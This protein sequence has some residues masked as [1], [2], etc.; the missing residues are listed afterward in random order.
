MKS[1]TDKLDVIKRLTD[2]EVEYWTARDLLAILGYVEWRNFEQAIK[3]ARMA[4]D[5]AGEKSENHFVETTNMVSVGSG[6]MRSVPDYYLSRA[7]CYIISMNGDTRKKEIAEA[8]KYFAIQT[9]RMERV[10]LALANYRRV[11]LRNRV[12]VHNQQLSGAA[13]DV[14][15]RR[16]GVFHG[17]GIKGMYNMTLNALRQ[18]RS[19]SE[20]DDWLDHAGIEELAANDFRITQTGAKLKREGVNSEQAAIDTH[21]SVGREV[22]YTIKRLG[23]TL[24]E[25]WPVEPPIKKVRQQLESEERRKI[26][27]QS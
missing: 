11:D 15:V 6:V 5:A 7:A 3:R 25:E 16:F 8:Q 12:Q 24:P 22:R 9:R 19:L 20:K 23:N 10:Q 21:A 18:R 1:I 17:M 14:G 2:R 26:T 4:F 27:N 13:K